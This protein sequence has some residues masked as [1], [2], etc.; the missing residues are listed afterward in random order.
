[1][2]FRL[3]M[4]FSASPSVNISVWRAY[5]ST[6]QVAGLVVQLDGKLA[7]QN[8]AQMGIISPPPA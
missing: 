8:A 4:Y 5:Q 1:M 3:Y 7:M 6:S 2:Y